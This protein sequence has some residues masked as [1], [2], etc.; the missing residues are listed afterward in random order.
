MTCSQCGWK[1]TMY[2]VKRLR[3]SVRFGKPVFQRKA[4]KFRLD[5]VCLREGLEM[6]W[7]VYMKAFPC[8]TADSSVL[9]NPFCQNTTRC[10]C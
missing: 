5:F 3:N 8:L 7:C 6:V 2:L 4:L 9:S 1:T 10:N